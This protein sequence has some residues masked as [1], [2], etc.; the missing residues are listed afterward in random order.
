MLFLSINHPD[1]SWQLGHI[2][3][4]IEVLMKLFALTTEQEKFFLS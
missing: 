4:S 1:R 2:T 3:N